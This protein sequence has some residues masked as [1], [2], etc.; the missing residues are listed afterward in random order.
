MFA[1]RNRFA[2][3]QTKTLTRQFANLRKCPAPVSDN[4]MQ[5][6]PWQAS[7]QKELKW[8]QSL[9][10]NIWFCQK[11]ILDLLKQIGSSIFISL[12]P[13]QIQY[14]IDFA[15]HFETVQWS[16]GKSVC[17][18]NGRLGF[19]SRLGQTNDYLVPLLERL[20][21]KETVWSLH[22]V[23]YAGGSLTQRTKGSFAVSWPGKLGE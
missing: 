4:E 11:I 18:W 5:N 2:N 16:S 20:A 21:L 17:Y 19:D 12:S 23:W 8:L 10:K 13:H 1:V 3:P 14:N 9:R 6:E 7:T 22:R 15:K